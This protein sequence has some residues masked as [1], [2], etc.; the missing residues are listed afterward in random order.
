MLLILL[1]VKVADCVVLQVHAQKLLLVEF[2][3][4]AAVISLE[5]GKCL[6]HLLKILVNMSWD[7]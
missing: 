3:L 7:V 2:L 6:F 1:F 5:L 4:E